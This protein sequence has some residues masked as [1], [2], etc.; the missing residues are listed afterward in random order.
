MKVICIIIVLLS[1]TVTSYDSVAMD[2]V[3]PDTC[4]T[5]THSMQGSATTWSIPSLQPVADRAKQGSSRSNNDSSPHAAASN[6]PEAFVLH[7]NFP[8]P[9]N[10]NTF[11]KIELPAEAFISLNIF[12]VQGRHVVQLVNS[13][14]PAGVYVVPWDGLDKA[15]NAVSSG[16]YYYRFS[17][18]TFH[19]VKRL[20]LLR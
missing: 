8:N 12:D 5:K 2:S 20:M 16:M 17:A 1:S 7:Q 11:I 4:I 3:K 10:S 9:F 15:G 19:A 18:E 6:E 13:R 14:Q